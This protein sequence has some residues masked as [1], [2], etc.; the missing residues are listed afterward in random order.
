MNKTID[1]WKDSFDFA[2][3]GFGG[4]ALLAL[5]LPLGIVG[6][7]CAFLA[8]AFGVLAAIDDT[9]TDHDH[10][11]RGD[12]AFDTGRHSN[13]LRT[14]DVET[15][16]ES[17]RGYLGREV[18]VRYWEYGGQPKLVRLLIDVNGAVSEVFGSRFVV[19]RDGRLTNTYLGS[20]LAFGPVYISEVT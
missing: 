10:D 1:K 11:D 17:L 3:I 6:L 20:A 12:S 8:G 14:T 19:S 18:D 4:L 5:F 15:L 7:L 13:G 16:E 9:E 2:A